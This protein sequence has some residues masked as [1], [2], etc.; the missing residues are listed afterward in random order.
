MN[1]IYQKMYLKGKKKSKGVL[2]GFIDNV[3]LR[4]FYSES[5]P[6]GNLKWLGC[7]VKASRHDDNIRGYRVKASRH[8][9]HI[10]NENIND[11]TINNVI[12]RSFNSES[13]PFSIKR[14]GFTLIE[15]LVV[16]LIIG[17]LAAIA[18]PQYQ[19]AVLKSRF[20]SFMP[21]VRALI[22]AQEVYYMA[23]GRYAYNLSQLDV[24]IPEDCRA[25][26]NTSAPNEILCGTDWLLDNVSSRMEPLGVMGVSYCPGNNTNGS[27]SCVPVSEVSLTFYYSQHAEKPDQVSCS[28]KTKKGTLLCHTL[29]GI[30]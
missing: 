26:S 27:T 7:R 5:R 19:V 21:T 1:K 4:G 25:R 17:I 9:D 29:K 18:L 6:F 8:D 14:A 15:L 2:G 10:N 20:M 23:N 11:D 12:L 28:A 30:F 16:V 3:I 22:N 24:Q 13:Q